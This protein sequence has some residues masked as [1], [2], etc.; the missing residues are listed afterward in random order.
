[1]A[2]QQIVVG[3]DGSAGAR[4]AL[5]WAADESRVRGCRLLVVHASGAG[6]ADPDAR[7]DGRTLEQLLNSHVAAASARQPGVAVSTLLS[8]DD[9]VDTLVGLS[10]DAE[11]VVVGTRGRDIATLGSVSHSVAMRAH[12]PVAVVPERN[13]APASGSRQR[14]VVGTSFGSVGRQALDFARAE[15]GLRGATLQTVPVDDASVDA[16]VRE[17]EGAQLLVV[18]CRPGDGTPGSRPVPVPAGILHRGPCPVVV[19]GKVC[20]EPSHTGEAA[21]VQALA[22][23]AGGRA[24]GARGSS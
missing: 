17:A 20:H 9:P 8:D 6:N 19:V 3:V 16:L 4:A 15:A 24:A 2:G 13:L 1:M 7:L 10:A 12:C 18:A 11:L 22:S 21:G 14:V 5:G 23:E